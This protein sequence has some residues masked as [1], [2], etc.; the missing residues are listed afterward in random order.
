MSDSMKL[1]RLTLPLII[2][3]WLFS[4]PTGVAQTIKGDELPNGGGGLSGGGGGQTNDTT[5]PCEDFKGGTIGNWGQINASLSIQQPG[6]TGSAGIDST[7]RRRT[8]ASTGRGNPRR[9]DRPSATAVSAC[10]TTTSR[11]SSA[12]SRAARRF[13]CSPS[14]DSGDR[15]ETANGAR[16]RAPFA[17][18]RCRR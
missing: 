3:A 9:W 7:A 5:D 17:V 15:G 2:A 16:R 10:T 18:L 13:W 12:S 11:S 8:T 14:G 1:H 4:L 6:P